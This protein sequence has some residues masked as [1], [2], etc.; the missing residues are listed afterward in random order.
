[1]SK[2]YVELTYRATVKGRN[3]EDAY[4]NARREMVKY[5]IN[6]DVTYCEEV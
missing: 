5:S 1:M 4:K 6:A 2:F 3:K